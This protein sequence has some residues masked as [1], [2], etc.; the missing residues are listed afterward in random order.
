[1]ARE[2]L[3]LAIDQGTTNTKALLLSQRGAIVAAASRPL[4]VSFPQ[5]GWVEQDARELWQST[6]RAAADCLKQIQNAEIAAIGISNQRESVVVWDRRTGEPIAPCVVWQCRRTIA[7]CSQ[8]K[9]RGL[10]EFIHERSG[11]SIDP[12]FSGSKIGWLLAEAPDGRSRAERG[13]LCAGTVD[14]W[15]LWNLTGGAIHATD[16]SNASR[17]QLLNLHRVQW[18][19]ELLNLF[20]VPRKCLPE[21]RS[22]SGVFGFTAAAGPFP[23]GIPVGSLIGDSHAALFG[24][25]AFRPGIVKATY[26]TGSSVMTLTETPIR[27]RRGLSTTIAWQIGDKASYALEG[28]ITNTGGT[29]QWLGELLSLSN[30]VEGVADLAATVSD[31]GGVY[32]VP[33]FA[34]L[35]APHWD[36]L[37]RGLITGLTRASSAAH[38]SRAALESI[39]FQIRD[40]FNVMASEAGIAAPVLHADGGA[41]RNDA[42]MQFQTDILACPIVRSSSADLSAQGA[43]WMAGL[44]VG[45]WNSLDELAGLPMECDHFTPAVSANRRQQ[46]LEG[47]RSALR[48][49]SSSQHDVSSEHNERELARG[50]N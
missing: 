44:A 33:A 10:D 16:A 3:I 35:G 34:G 2:K 43:G 30:P 19:D 32:I 7:L 8:L 42:L 41:S 47:W 40:V 22:S 9:S 14:S 26:G 1:V 28:N 50:A 38:L 48:R 5:D 39:A 18:D 37:A 4:S 15:L 24:H 13:E 12:L 11:L 36:P 49:A 27:S 23:A 31:S 45:F 17:T 6:L 20:G 25:A 29:V 46:L 21:V